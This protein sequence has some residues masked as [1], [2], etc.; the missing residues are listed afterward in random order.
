VEPCRGTRA[1]LIRVAAE[2]AG[3]D[4]LWGTTWRCEYQ[5]QSREGLH[6]RGKLPAFFRKGVNRIKSI[7]VGDN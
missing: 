6:R 5:L 3:H 7:I 4:D 2:K 1:S